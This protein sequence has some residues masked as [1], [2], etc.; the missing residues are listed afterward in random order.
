MPVRGF[1]Q[2]N[3][4]SPAK[5]RVLDVYPHEP[6]A[7]LLLIAGRTAS[8][9]PRWRWR[10]AQ[11]TR[12]VIVNADASQV[13]DAWRVILPARLRRKRHWHQSYVRAMCRQG[14]LIP[15]VTG[16]VRSPEVLQQPARPR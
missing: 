10:L 2:R 8:V 3:A 4:E 15:S 14:T 1:T 13:Y 9:N 5:S 16:C 7:S 12:R 11:R 6:R